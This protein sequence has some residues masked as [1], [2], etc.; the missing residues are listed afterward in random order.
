MKRIRER[1]SSRYRCFNFCLY[2]LV[3]EVDFENDD[4]YKMY[5][6]KCVFE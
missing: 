2:F 6:L 4:S 3:E 5:D 1:F